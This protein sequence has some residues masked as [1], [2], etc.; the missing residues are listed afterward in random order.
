MRTLELYMWDISLQKKLEAN[1]KL[2]IKSFILFAPQNSWTLAPRHEILVH[3]YCCHNSI[4]L[5]WGITANKQ[6]NKYEVLVMT[7][8]HPHIAKKPHHYLLQTLE[9]PKPEISTLCLL[10]CLQSTRP[11]SACVKGSRTQWFG[12]PQN[13]KTLRDLRRHLQYLENRDAAAADSARLCWCC[14]AALATRL[15]TNQI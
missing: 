15:S 14:K 8:H 1:F 6:K 5:L 12:L 9:I 13:A 11:T 4:D 3:I 7:I 10:A 2:R